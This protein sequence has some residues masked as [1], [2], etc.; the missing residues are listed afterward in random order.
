MAVK[1]DDKFV[2]PFITDAE[3]SAA[4]QK[5]SENEFANVLGD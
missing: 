5:N 2:K 3:L 4:I 1:L